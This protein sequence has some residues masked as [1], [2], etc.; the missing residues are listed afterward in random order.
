MREDTLSDY[1]HAV[2]NV[3]CRYCSRRGRYRRGRLISQYGGDLSLDRF[4]RI[5]ASDCGYAQV[6]TVR[7][8]CNGPYMVLPCSAPRGGSQR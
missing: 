4:M 3:A 7:A 6:R 1:P 5:I 8:G 2:I